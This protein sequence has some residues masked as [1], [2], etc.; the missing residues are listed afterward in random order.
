MPLAP[1]ALGL[2][3]LS[4]H[5]HKWLMV[6]FGCGVL[7]LA[8][9]ALEQIQPRFVGEQSYRDGAD[10]SNPT[11]AW[12]DGARRFAVGSANIL[13][14]TA[15]ASALA[16]VIELGLTQIARHNAALTQDLIDGLRHLA[17]AV[18]L[19]VPDVPERRAAIVVCTTGDAARDAALVEQLASRRI[20]VACRPRGI[21]VAPHLFNDAAD[22]ATLVRALAQLSR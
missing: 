5:G 4:F 1:Q 11:P 19:V 8:P 20:M 13:G 9:A 2:A 12:R 15:L 14:M 10:P 7:Y 3:A 18:R 6:G 17:P 16:L 22:I 21:R